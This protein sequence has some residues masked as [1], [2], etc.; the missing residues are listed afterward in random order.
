[1][2][3]VESRGRGTDAILMQ[4]VG[5]PRGVRVVRLVKHIHGGLG[6]GQRFGSPSEFGVL[7][8]QMPEQIGLVLGIAP[9]PVFS[10]LFFPTPARTGNR[11][12]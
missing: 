9:C 4:V 6:M 1:M 2:H 5:K 12:C 8:R 11:S 7:Y 3:R 10:S